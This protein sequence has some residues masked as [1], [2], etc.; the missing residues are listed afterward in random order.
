MI[1]FEAAVQGFARAPEP[2]EVEAEDPEEAKKRKIFGHT[3]HPDGTLRCVSPSQYKN[4]KRC[5]RLWYYD[6]VLKRPRKKKGKGAK[7]GTEC[8]GRMEKFLKTGVDIRG[9]LERHGHE[10]I[11]PYLARAP[12]HDGDMLVEAPLLEPQIVTP[13]GILISGFSD[14]TL[15]PDDV[16]LVQV[17]DHKFKKKLAQYADTYEDL[18]N[19]DPQAVIYS[20]WALLRWPEAVAARFAHHNH[21]TEG[22]RLNLPVSIADERA[23]V[24][25]K[26]A[27]LG[28]YI[29]EDM[30]RTAV[31]KDVIDVPAAGD[32]NSQA[33]KAFGGC[34]YMAECPS[35]PHNRYMNALAGGSYLPENL[36]LSRGAAEPPTTQGY[37]LMGL[38]DEMMDA[39][40]P[41]ATPAATTTTVPAVNAAPRTLA[42]LEASTCKAGGIYMIPGGPVG[43]FEGVMGDRAIFKDKDGGLLACTLSDYVRD[44]NGD[45]VASA[46]FEK[47]KKLVIDDLTD[48]GLAAKAAAKAATADTTPKIDPA[49]GIVPKDAPAD[50]NPP[51]APVTPAPAAP[52]VTETPAPAA[53][54]TTPEPEKPAAKRG[55]PAGSKNKVGTELIILVNN[56]CP[57]AEDLMPYV[58]GMCDALAKKANLA[59]VRLAEKGSDLAY[60]AWKAILAVMCKTNPPPPGLYVVQRTELTEPVIEALSTVGIVSHGGRG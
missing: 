16:P 39:P 17:L 32:T 37:D 4:H 42:P 50:T 41:A 20:V 57:A 51:K 47:K 56:A 30:A 58:Q 34:D 3:L 31:I 5:N 22:A 49:A 28:K 11:E 52:A 59:D 36:T 24:F 7:L 6:K 26:W 60:G 9:Q 38:L 33:C 48:E 18:D 15:P 35:S 8:H 19:G 23:T 1:D 2:E 43:K 10:M 44:L 25:A 27:K 45:P 29:D 21:Q 53:T 40:K 13:G 55:R 12:F 54:T 14:V 46:L